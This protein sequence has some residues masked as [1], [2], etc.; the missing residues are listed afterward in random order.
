MPKNWTEFSL[1]ASRARSAISTQDSLALR[2]SCLYLVWHPHAALPH[3]SALD[4]SR[5]GEFGYRAF[6][7]DRVVWLAPVV[8][9]LRVCW[10]W[11]GRLQLGAGRPRDP[12]IRR[13]SIAH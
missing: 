4:T 12:P 2:S 7:S 9:L 10:S 13:R 3:I 6:H 8:M 11:L 1:D 5:L